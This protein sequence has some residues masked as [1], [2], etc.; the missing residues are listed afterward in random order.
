MN[1]AAPWI[2]ALL[3]SVLVNGAMAG[4]VLHRTSGGP[5]WRPDWRDGHGEHGGPRHGRDGGGPPPGSGG[6]NMRAFVSALPEAERAAAR[7][8]L[9]AHREAFGDLMR[10]AMRARR[11]AELALTAQP[12][13]PDAAAAALA[14]VRETRNAIEADVEAI[15]LDIVAELSVEEREAALL[16]GRRGGPERRRRGPPPDRR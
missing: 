11:E 7:E 1:R 13:D 2:V 5:D 12:Y 10:D 3:I 8:R 9:R 15:V 4:F 16:A 14:Q 6:F